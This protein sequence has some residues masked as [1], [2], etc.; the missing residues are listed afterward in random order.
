MS[1]EKQ[2]AVYSASGSKRWLE[3]PGV[4]ELSKQA[5]PQFD[6]QYSKEGTTAHSCLEHMLRNSNTP[7][8]RK[9]LLKTYSAD[10]VANAEFAFN[11]IEELKPSET[12]ELLIE[13]KVD[14]SFIEPDQF[15]TL[16]AAWVDEFGTLVVIDYKYGQGLAVS[17]DANTQ[18]IYYGLCLAHKYDWN[19]SDVQLVIIQPR[20]EVQVSRSHMTIA[21]L[22]EWEKIFKDGVART[23]ETR[24]RLHAGDHC[25]WCPATTIC[26]EISKKQMALARIDFDEASGDVELPKV[27]DIG[28]PHLGQTLSAAEKIEFWIAELR[29]HASQ[30]LERGQP[31]SGFKL[32]EKRGTRKYL[33]AE[34]TEKEAVKKYGKAVLTEPELKSPAQLEKVKGVDAKWLA[35]QVTNVSSGTTMVPDSDP[36]PAVVAAKDDFDVIPERKKKRG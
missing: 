26:P 13:T 32:V 20:V 3:C 18:M 6:N 2:H 27:T 1:E 17:A 25:K 35:K 9:F 30:L 15:G 21:Q 14:F 5:P 19:F 31:V 8:V 33:N 4:I 10:M 34:K 36:R 16:D 22:R 7:A 12:A 11:A 29:A 28:I 23:K 24:P